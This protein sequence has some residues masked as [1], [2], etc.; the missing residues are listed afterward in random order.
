MQPPFAAV[1]GNPDTKRGRIPPNLRLGPQFEP[2]TRDALLADSIAFAV[3]WP[4]ACQG[5]LAVRTE[6]SILAMKSPFSDDAA[7]IPS[8]N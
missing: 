2:A 1:A 8:S 7:P 3:S 5:P 4:S 6:N